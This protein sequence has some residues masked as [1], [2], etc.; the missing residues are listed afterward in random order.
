[1]EQAVGLALWIAASSF[2]SIRAR[3]AKILP[4]PFLSPGMRA[5]PVVLVLLAML[6]W[7]WRVRVGRTY[8]RIAGGGAQEAA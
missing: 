4:E 6:Y 7:L 3:V 8:R 5:L 2:F 1:M